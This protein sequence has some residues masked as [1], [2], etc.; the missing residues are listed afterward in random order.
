MVKL[1]YGLAF[2]FQFLM[3]VLFHDQYH[4]AYMLYQL[5]NIFGR[6]QTIK[7]D[8]DSKIVLE[9]WETLPEVYYDEYPLLLER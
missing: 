8:I 4:K 6:T 3:A 9:F 1:Y 7:P 2:L 5:E